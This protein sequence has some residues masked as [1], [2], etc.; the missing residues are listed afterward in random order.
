MGIQRTGLSNCWE[1]QSQLNV[2]WETLVLKVKARDDAGGG[3]DD[4]DD[5]GSRLSR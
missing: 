1:I 4:D 3:H 2:R 5:D